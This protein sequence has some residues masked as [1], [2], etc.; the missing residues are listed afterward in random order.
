MGVILKKEMPF[1]LI[2]STPHTHG[3]D[4]FVMGFV[5]GIRGYSLHMGEI[6]SKLS[7]AE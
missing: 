7:M 2:F 3:G 5:K 6:T 1:V 4:S